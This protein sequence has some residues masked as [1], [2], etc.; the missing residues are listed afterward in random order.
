MTKNKFSFSDL[1]NDPIKIMA[2]IYPYFLVVII[3]IGFL[4]I[5]DSSALVQ[6]KVA[7]VLDDTT[8][9]LT[10]LPIADAK[11]AAAVDLKSFS[12]STP[13]LVEKGK[14]L[15]QNACA[16]CHGVEGNGDG[17]AGVALNP[18]PRNFHS[19]DGWKFGRKAT[20]IYNTLQKGILTSGMPGFDYLAPSDRIAI[21]Q[22]IRTWMPNPPQDTLDDISNLDKTYAL[23]AGTQIP[24]TVPVASAEKSLQTEYLAKI[25]KINFILSTLRTEKSQSAAAEAFFNVTNNQQK[26]LATLLN[27]TSWQVGEKEFLAVITDNLSTNGFSGKVFSLSSTEIANLFSLLKRVAV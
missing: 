7:P 15:F 8:E 23:S 1:L 5:G 12:E 17:A 6:N 24:G 9:V 2:L 19:I 26:A 4:Y 22:Y 14:Q 21:I 13:A 20:E 3:G 16:S 10:D 27:S 11:V 25:Q 18:K